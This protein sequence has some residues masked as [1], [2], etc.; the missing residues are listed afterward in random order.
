M[1]YSTCN[2]LKITYGKYTF[3]TVCISSLNLSGYNTGFIK[4]I[5]NSGCKNKIKILLSN[6]THIYMTSSIRCA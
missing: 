3:S 2:Y 4:K 6:S 5:I 1:T